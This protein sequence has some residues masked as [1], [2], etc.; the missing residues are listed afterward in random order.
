MCLRVAMPSAII[1]ET[2][3][4]KEQK[5]IGNAPSSQYDLEVEAQ[6]E[7]ERVTERDTFLSPTLTREE[8]Q[9]LSIAL[10][11]HPQVKEAYL[12]R[13]RLKTFPD[14]PFYVIAWVPK[15]KWYQFTSNA[16]YT[17][18][19]QVIADSTPCSERC[20]F[21]VLNGNRRKLAKKIKAIPGAKIA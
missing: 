19:N 18:E 3:H 1:F 17:E 9:T 20:V 10:M 13:K 21:I 5:S 8:T 14:R 4:P 2:G 16:N 11:T 12:I 15:L 7:V 6:A